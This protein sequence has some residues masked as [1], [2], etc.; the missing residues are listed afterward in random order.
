[1]KSCGGG[2]GSGSGGNG[3]AGVRGNGVG[4]GNDGAGAGGSGGCCGDDLLLQVEDGFAAIVRDGN[5]KE[6]KSLSSNYI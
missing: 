2:S 1:M 6:K 4:G 5:K 3:F